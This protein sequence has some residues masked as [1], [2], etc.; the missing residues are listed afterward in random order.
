MNNDGNT[1][2]LRDV[3]RKNVPDQCIP[4]CL[5]SEKVIYAQL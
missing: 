5:D 3:N 2:V 1:D 4:I